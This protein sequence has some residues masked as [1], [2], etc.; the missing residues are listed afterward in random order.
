MESDF[1]K[2]LKKV[3]TEFKSRY[4]VNKI[5]INENREEYEVTG[6]NEPYRVVLKFDE[7]GRLIEKTCTCPDFVYRNNKFCKHIIGVLMETGREYMFLAEYIEELR[8]IG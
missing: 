2:R 6:G 4:K 7:E 5:E 8:K 3:Y 1:R